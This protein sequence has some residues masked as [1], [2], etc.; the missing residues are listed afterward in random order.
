MIVFACLLQIVRTS[1]PAPLTNMPFEAPAAILVMGVAGVVMNIIAAMCA[2]AT[3]TQL[4]PVRIPPSLQR[5]RVR[6]TV[7]KRC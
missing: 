5:G 4:R 7:G 1:C 2:P 6:S 3:Q